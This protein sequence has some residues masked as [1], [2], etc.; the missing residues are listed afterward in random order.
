MSLQN[1][2]DTLSRQFDTHVSDGKIDNRVADNVLIAWPPIIEQINKKFPTKN[3]LSA[4]DFGCGTGSFCHELY[5]MG[6]AVTGVDY[7]SQ[8]VSVAKKHTPSAIQ[9]IVGSSEALANLPHQNLAVS[10]MTL[11]FVE[12]I[13]HATR[14]I[15][16]IIKPKGLI[17]FAVFNPGYVTACL[18][19]GK[20]FS[21]FD[22]VTR[23]KKGVIGFGNAE[24][25]VFIRDKDEYDQLFEAVGFKRTFYAKPPFTDSFRKQYP[26]YNPTH[27]P[28]Y[29]ILAYERE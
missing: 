24:I 27:V 15:T 20:F 21:K 17:I 8:M 13:E 1:Q 14:N 9:Y 7:S 11:Q 5:K 23:P 26:M 29:L 2:W 6:F 4:L 28:E 10:I 25:P 16:A 3:G 12:D 19:A 18:E 22:S